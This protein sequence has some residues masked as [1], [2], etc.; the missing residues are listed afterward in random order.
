MLTLNPVELLPVY[1]PEEKFN[2]FNQFNNAVLLGD[3]V[4]QTLALNEL[5][6]PQDM[7]DGFIEWNLLF[8]APLKPTEPVPAEFDTKNQ[9]E[10][11]ECE[12][13][14]FQDELDTLQALCLEEFNG[15][16]SDESVISQED[17]DFDLPW[18][19]HEM[20]LICLGV[21]GPMERC[22]I[23]EVANDLF[24]RNSR[25]VPTVVIRKDAEIEVNGVIL[26]RPAEKRSFE[27]VKSKRT[28][29]KLVQLT[30]M[31]IARLRAMLNLPLHGF[32]TCLGDT[33]LA[34][35]RAYARDPDF[36]PQQ[37]V[38]YLSRHSPDN[39]E[40]MMTVAL[41]KRFKRMKKTS[42]IS[43]QYQL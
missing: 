6:D 40:P 26:Y 36:D 28:G 38:K 10:L 27:L 42:S 37:V 11:S 29:R 23:K 15:S 32:E 43:K 4:G 30:K 25:I 34:M 21:V 39:D 2:P 13:Q 18:T 5:P 20:M 9:A 35:H 16:Y 24:F 31:G 19:R 22:K 14:H 7:F 41:A 3:N 33:E 8:S 12:A 17:V 1:G